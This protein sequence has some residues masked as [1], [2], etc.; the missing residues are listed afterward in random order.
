MPWGLQVPNF[1]GRPHYPYRHPIIQEVINI[2][3]FRNKDDDG[4]VF[5]EYF[6]PIPI[7]VIGLVLTVVRIESTRRY[8]GY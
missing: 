3:W 1:G 6:V 5:R 7:E 8:P 2:M 4:I